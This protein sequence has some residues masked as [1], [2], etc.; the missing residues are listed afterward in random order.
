[1]SPSHHLRTEAGP[2]SETSWLYILYFI[3]TMN[4]V[5][6]TIG[7]QRSYLFCVTS[8]KNEDLRRV[9]SWCYRATLDSVCARGVGKR[10]CQC[11]SAN[12]IDWLG[13]EPEIPWWECEDFARSTAQSFQF[14]APVKLRSFGSRNVLLWRCLE[15]MRRAEVQD[16][17]AVLIVTDWAVRKEQVE[18]KC[19]VIKL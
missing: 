9:I 6:K 16:G 13:I 1:V 4:K 19:G 14:V 8:K 18:F 15:E 7:S 12:H 10:L 11:V 17:A 5:Q 2:A 3:L